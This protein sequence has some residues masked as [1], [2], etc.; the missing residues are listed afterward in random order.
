MPVA[1]A[2]RTNHQAQSRQSPGRKQMS[3]G[4]LE[5]RVGAILS[6]PLDFIDSDLFHTKQAHCECRSVDHL[7]E[8]VEAPGPAAPEKSTVRHLGSVHLARMCA[9]P[10]LTADEEQLL[11]RRLN[12]VKMRASKLRRRLL[13]THAQLELVEHIEEHLSEIQAI[14]RRLIQS[15]LR[16]VA[17]LVKKFVNE[18]NAF[19]E[20]FSE[21]VMSLMRAVEKFDFAFGY[22][23]STYATQAIRR[24]LYR[25]VV[26]RQQDR[27][28]FVAAEPMI[29]EEVEDDRTSVGFDEEGWSHRI[30]LLEKVLGQLDERE[31]YIVKR[32]Y[33]LGDDRRAHTLQSLAD[34][35]GVCKERVRQLQQRALGKL[36][37]MADDFDQEKLGL[38][39]Q[40]R[41]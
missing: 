13:K 24:H 21:G 27:I 28:R 41:D 40:G 15:N 36:V 30:S 3:A 29:M 39:S 26:N 14:E 25:E 9:V 19:D 23:F 8:V 7:I 10:L 6:A 12:Y 16:L 18:S 22:R 4:R 34:E 5:A 17:S 1:N 31:R 38:L 11:F 2:N 20:L 35:L 37:S 32:R 33:G